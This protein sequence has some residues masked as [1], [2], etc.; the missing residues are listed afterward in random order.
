MGGVLDPGGELRTQKLMSLGL[1]IKTFV[2][3]CWGYSAL[4][5]LRIFSALGNPPPPVHYIIED[6]MIFLIFTILNA[7]LQKKAPAGMVGLVFNDLHV[8]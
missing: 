8:F 2:I 3:I 5:A 4:N 6:F 1:K 7:L